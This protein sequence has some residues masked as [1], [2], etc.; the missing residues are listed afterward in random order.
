MSDNFMID[1]T[2]IRKRAKKARSAASGEIAATRRIFSKAV[3]K[4][5]LEAIQ[6]SDG[7]F[8]SV[9][10]LSIATVNTDEP[11]GLR[12]RQKLAAQMPSTPDHSF[13]LLNKGFSPKSIGT[14]AINIIIDELKRQY[15]DCTVQLAPGYPEEGTILSIDELA[16]TTTDV[17]TLV[18]EMTEG[19]LPSS[20]SNDDDDDDDADDDG[21]VDD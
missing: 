15:V 13:V 12:V 11:L 8:K 6:Q 10:N 14:S 18:I 19:E 4:A 17:A 20:F 1:V 7:S 21:D 2:S 16:I 9:I 5:L 3:A